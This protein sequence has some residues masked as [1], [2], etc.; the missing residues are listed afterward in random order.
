M[1]NIKIGSNKK[2]KRKHSTV[3]LD[4]WEN[5]TIGVLHDISKKF[6][7]FETFSQNAFIQQHLLHSK[8]SFFSFFLIFGFPTRQ[9]KFRVN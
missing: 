2:N 8:A 3:P 5:Q 7:T 9:S 4:F 1:K 6:K